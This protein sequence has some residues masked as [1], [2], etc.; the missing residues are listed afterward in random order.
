MN[1]LNVS[2]IIRELDEKLP[3]FSDGRV[4]Y[5]K[6]D[7]APVISVFVKYGDEILLLKRSE[8]VRHYKSF[9]NVVGGYLDEIRPMR[10]KVLE[11]VEEELNITES[12][13][14][15]IK[16]GEPFEF[17]DKKINKT[18]FVHPVLVVLKEKVNIKLDWEH[19]EY[20][21]IKIDQL[22]KYKTI[23]NLKMSLEN[24]I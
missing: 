2:D 13:I 1:K 3:N 11:E 17:K 8:T 24:L 9:W 21:W 19:I 14:A 15:S 23:P 20:K 4:D 7:Y 16:F 10:L 5:T 18:W 6:S 12:Q 22:S